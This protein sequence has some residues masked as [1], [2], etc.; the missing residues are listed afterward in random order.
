MKKVLRN[1]LV[2]LAEK[3]KLC[4]L[5]I[6]FLGHDIENGTIIHIDRAIEFASKFP[7]E[8]KDRKNNCKEFLGNL[9]YVADFYKGL[10]QDGAC[11]YQRL[12]KQRSTWNDNHA[13]AVRKMKLKVKQIP[14]LSLA[15]LKWFK[16]VEIDA[17]YV[18]DGGILK[19]QRPRSKNEEL[20]G[21]TIILKKNYS[22]I[23]EEV[24]AIV[25][26]IPKF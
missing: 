3:M 14:C 5:K 21:Y 8:I 17:S 20:V 7:D 16:I 23:K 12:K 25:K 6:R 9:N 26:C 1:G 2:V 22:T 24:L 19:Q 10:A 13:S 18:G 15:N 4:Q 11:L